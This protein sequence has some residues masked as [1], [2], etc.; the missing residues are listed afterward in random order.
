[1]TSEIRANT[2]KNRVGLGTVE[3][4]DTGTIVSGIITATGADINGDIDV[5]GH[6]N[7]DNVSIAGIVTASG[8]IFLPDSQILNIGNTSSTGDLQFFSDGTYS[9]IKTNALLKFRGEDI[10]LMNAAGSETFIICDGDNGGAGVGNVNLYFDS[11]RKFRTLSYGAQVE[12]ATGDTSLTVRAEEDNSS[13]DAILKTS[14][15]NSNA[16]GYIFFGDNDD[17][18]VGRIRYRHSNNSMSF[19]VNGGSEALKIDSG[20]NVQIG[21]SPTNLAAIGAGPT[22]GINGAAPEITLRDTATNNPY[23]WIATNDLGSL[24][25]AADQGNNANSS[26]IDFRVDGTERVRITSGGEVKIAD[27][28]FLSINTNPASTYGVAE[29]LR[30]DD[31]AS[32]GD[33]ALQIFE[34]HHGGA[35]Y[36][37]IQFNTNTTTNGSAY[38]YTQG[39]YGGSSSIEFD[40]SGHLSFFTDAEVSSGSQSNI[41]PTERLHISSTGEVGINVSPASGHLLHIKNSSADSKLKI[42]SESG[43]DARLILDTSNG[44]GAGAHIDFQIDGTLKGGIQYVSNASASDTHDIVFRNNSNTER[45]RITSTGQTLLTRGSQGG[46]DSTGNASNF[47]K[48]GT[49][50]GIDQTSRLKITIFGTS[51]YDAN[52]D[53]AGET[54]IYISNNANNTMKGHFHSHSNN[55]SCVQKVA[56]KYDSSTSPTSCQVWIKYNGGYSSTQHK[57]DASEGYWVG[58]DVDL[59]STSV[60]SGATEASSFFSVAT[61]DGSQSYERL[62]ISSG[63]DLLV[64]GTTLNNSSVA[65]QALQINGTTR[66]TL[67]LRGNASGGNTCEIQFADNSGTDSDAGTRAGLI[68]YEHSGTY[69]NHMHFH[70]NETERMVINH[71]GRVGIAQSPAEVAGFAEQLQVGGIYGNNYAAAFKIKQSS[72]SLMR[73]ATT[74]SGSYNLCGGITVNGSSTSFNTSSDYRLKENDVKISDGI[75]R[76]KQLRPIRFNWK[77]DPSTTEDGFFAHEVSP[78]VPESVNGEKDATIDEIGEGYQKIDHSKLVPLLTAALQEAITE[79]ETLKTKVAALEGS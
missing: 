49:W 34:Y 12:S 5:D 73:F 67:I 70:T 8:G 9:H 25:L 20:G 54:I 30:I 14:V 27:G 56:F 1:M 7:L 13:A 69:A 15:T 18:D 32:A 3:Y 21:D 64:R 26:I 36:H 60:P 74:V 44:G 50:Y 53:V 2:I 35:R 61:S 28:G 51:T 78:V 57:V 24:V 71:Q 52:A 6:T 42:E 63:G 76:L 22:L 62:R 59:H 75:T 66:P 58:A 40:N 10:R 41:T 38:T 46:R 11:D 48:I 23:A 43:N 72:G 37:R 16:S 45:L 19:R 77:A 39:N 29:A 68:K 79:I 65:G 17:G 31:G 47:M 55:R 4:A 33:R